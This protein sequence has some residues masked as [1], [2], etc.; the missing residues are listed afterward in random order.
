MEKIELKPC[1]FCGSRNVKILSA[2]LGM[3]KRVECDDCYAAAPAESTI[4]EELVF[5][6]NRRLSP[7]CMSLQFRRRWIK[8]PMGINCQKPCQHPTE[9]LRFLA[10][11]LTCRE[12]GMERTLLCDDMTWTDWK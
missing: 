8:S 2:A 12:C 9:K 3:A 7:R 11:K 6:W 5:K 10:P 1:P 4:E